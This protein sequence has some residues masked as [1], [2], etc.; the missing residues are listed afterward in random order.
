MLVKQ[1]GIAKCVV[2]SE[3]SS[4]GKGFY[5]IITAYPLPRIPNFAK[6]G[7]RIIWER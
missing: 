2:V 3:A 6:R 4:D 5:K 7:D 1:N